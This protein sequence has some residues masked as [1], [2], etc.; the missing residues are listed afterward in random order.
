MGTYR[1]W[2]I[3]AID[4]YQEIYHLVDIAFSSH[5]VHSWK[6][7]QM[8]LVVSLMFNKPEQDR[9]LRR[10]CM[11]CISPHQR[12]TD[13]AHVHHGNEGREALSQMGN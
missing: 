9:W 11:Q 4:T 13:A 12:G 7:S 8:K 6:P 10:A 5:G 1:M 2:Q 3:F